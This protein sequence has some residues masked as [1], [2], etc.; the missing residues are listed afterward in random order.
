MSKAAPS[1]TPAATDVWFGITTDCW[2]VPDDI[3]PALR[4]LP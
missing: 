3:F 2:A 4:W 1:R